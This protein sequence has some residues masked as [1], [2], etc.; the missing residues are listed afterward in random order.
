MKLSLL[1]PQK[2]RSLLSPFW[3]DDNLD[4]IFYG[5]LPNDGNAKFILSVD[6]KEKENSYEICAD[7]PG[8]TPENVKVTLEKGVLNIQ[9]E[10]KCETEEKKDGYT[11]IERSFGTFSRSFRLPDDIDE[12]QVNA[13]YKNGVL[14]LTIPKSHASQ[15]KSIDIK[16]H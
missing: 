1:H 16:I 15:P 9:G 11:H 2:S 5:L 8:M 14:E 3:L 13:V 4:S 12:S 10:R 6:I 7:L